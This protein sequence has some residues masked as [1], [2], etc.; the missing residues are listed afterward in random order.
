MSEI[1]N[2]SARA[3]NI[4]NLPLESGQQQ[5][6]L[7]FGTVKFRNQG[8]RQIN[9]ET[10]EGAVVRNVQPFYPTLHF[11]YPA[12]PVG[13]VVLW[14]FAD[15][16]ASQPFYFAVARPPEW[17]SATEGSVKITG[18]Q[19]QLNPAEIVRINGVSVA[20]IGAPDDDGDILVDDNQVAPQIPN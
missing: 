9:L 13:S 15:G 17:A 11:D 7:R 2:D 5:P 4:S 12:P 1:F 3:G 14:G 16:L 20:V 10:A 6:G 18:N 8:T 19:V